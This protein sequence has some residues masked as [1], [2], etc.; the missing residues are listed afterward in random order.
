MENCEMIT[1]GT[2]A[3]EGRRERHPI[4]WD[5]RTLCDEYGEV[6]DGGAET[7]MEA[8]EVLTRLFGRPYWDLRL[9]AD[10]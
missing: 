9:S 7:L 6:A 1:V 5:G 10:M 3:I 2:I 4:W 8:Q